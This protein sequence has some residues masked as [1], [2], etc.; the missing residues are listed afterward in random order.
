MPHYEFFN[1]PWCAKKVVDMTYCYIGNVPP[2]PP[3]VIYAVDEDTCLAKTADDGNTWEILPKGHNF[4]DSIKCVAV[5]SLN[6]DIVYKGVTGDRYETGIMRSSDGGY[7][8]TCINNGLPDRIYPSK[9]GIFRQNPDY[10]LLGTYIELGQTDDRCLFKTTDGGN[11]WYDRTPTPSPTIL[12]ITDFSF[13]PTV[14]RIVCLSADQSHPDNAYCGVWMSTDFGE[15]WS[16]IGRPDNMSFPE[17]TCVLIVSVDTI[18]AG[19][20]TPVNN[21]TGVQRTTDGGI[22]WH[23]CWNYELFFIITDIAVDSLNH[24]NVYAS[25]GSGFALL[26]DWHEE[27]RGVIRSTDGGDTWEDWN[28]GLTDLFVHSLI[29]NWQEPPRL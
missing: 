8:W 29:F 4:L 6:P 28:E 5:H 19:Y 15:T 23:V 10:L 17:A 14:S 18:Y 24:D 2:Y 21:L 25:Y 12:N 11:S 1:G 16:H 13:H 22:S 26:G 20:Y 7:T 9:L 27:G 3:P